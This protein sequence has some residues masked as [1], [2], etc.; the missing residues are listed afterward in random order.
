MGRRGQKQVSA[1]RPPGPDPQRH[2]C[3]GNQCGWHNRSTHGLPPSS[4][5][6]RALAGKMLPAAPRSAQAFRRRPPGRAERERLTPRR[7]TESEAKTMEPKVG[8]ACHACAECNQWLPGQLP[9]P[10]PARA[11][12]NPHNSA[13]HLAPPLFRR[14]RSCALDDPV[15]PTCH[16]AQRTQTRPLRPTLWREAALTGC[17]TPDPRRS[18]WGWPDC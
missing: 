14:A 3:Y 11:T 16:T 2:E 5:R 7:C 18:S 9:T 12:A 1:L 15:A 13:Q 4:V 10:A 17:A 8:H 6:N